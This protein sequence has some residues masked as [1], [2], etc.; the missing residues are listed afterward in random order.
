[1]TARERTS[2]SFSKNW[3][4]FL[5]TD[6]QRLVEFAPGGKHVGDFSQRHRARAHVTLLFIHR[7]F[8]LATDTQRLVEFAPGRKHVRL[9]AP[10]QRRFPCFAAIKIK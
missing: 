3:Q 6:A 9:S 4:F 7:Q 8:F 5:A 1:M 2:P 10:G